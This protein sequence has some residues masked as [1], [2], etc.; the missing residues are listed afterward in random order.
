[1]TSDD[2]LEEREPLE[3]IVVSE[4]EGDVLRVARA[5]VGISPVGAVMEILETPR[6]ATTRSP[7]AM[8]V[9]EDTLARGLVRELVR[10][11]GHRVVRSATARGRLWERHAPVKLALGPPSIALLKWLVETQL[12]LS[13]RITPLLLA[14]RAQPTLGDE[15]VYYLGADLL[16]RARLASAIGTPAFAHSTLVAI[17]FPLQSHGEATPL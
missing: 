9:L 3:P 17:G 12:G 14:P 5:L 6:P 1:M 13:A 7:D 16:A 2:A 8:E 10:R 15:L 11:G 4:E